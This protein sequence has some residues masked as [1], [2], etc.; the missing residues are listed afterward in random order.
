MTKE[1]VEQLI[2]A[3]G[4][5]YELGAR[6][7]EG[8][9]G[10]VY[11]SRDTWQGEDVA[12]KSICPSKQ[13]KM[14]EKRLHREICVLA[15]LD[16]PHIV[17]MLNLV[18]DHGCDDLWIVMELVDGEEL[19]DILKRMEGR[20][21]PDNTARCYLQ[22]LLSAVH[23]MHT[24]NIAHRDLKPPNLMVNTKT[25]VLKVTDFGLSNVQETDAEG[26]VLTRMELVTR[27]GTPY[28]IAPEVVPR[29]KRTDAKKSGYSGFK[30]DMWSMGIILYNMLSGALPFVGRDLTELFGQIRA[31]TYPLPDHV[32]SGAREAIARLLV[33]DPRQRADCRELVAVEWVADGF[34]RQALA[35]DAFDVSADA[36]SLVS[37]AMHQW[38]LRS[39]PLTDAGHPGFGAGDSRGGLL[40][41]AEP[42]RH[43]LGKE[44]ARG[45]DPNRHA[46]EQKLA[47]MRRM[48][49]AS[50]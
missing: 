14:G 48:A 13:A 11:R 4:R 21:L 43:N 8:Q 50:E 2:V 27:C 3:D 31:G 16:H 25:G 20:R 42:G 49:A 12:V 35:V 33:V 32:S 47:E 37:T 30:S 17:R 41:E 38:S 39:S 36:M 5:R 46:Y 15:A 22:Q 1:R 19:T 24:Q 7:G 34:P 28:Y 45:K 26:N 44:S 6:L 18:C 23:Y 10:I 9:F 29:A 40:G